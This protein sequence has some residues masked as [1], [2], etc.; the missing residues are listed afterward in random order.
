M[1]DDAEIMTKLERFARKLATDSVLLAVLAGCLVLLTAAATIP[2]RKASVV[3]TNVRAG[4]VE[5][6]MASDYGP[7]VD[8]LLG[9]GASLDAS[10]FDE[11]T[12]LEPG[13]RPSS[14]AH[15]EGEL[16]IALLTLRK[17]AVLRVGSA[18]AQELNLTIV[19]PASSQISAVGRVL[20]NGNPC[21]NSGAA[22]TLVSDRGHEAHLVAR[23]APNQ[24]SDFRLQDLHVSELAFLHH[25]AGAA[26]STGQTSS[27]RSGQLAV[28]ESGESI[29]L[30][31]GADVTLGGVN[32]LV[33]TIAFDKDGFSVAF[34]G[35]AQ[36]IVLREGTDRRDL[37]PSILVWLSR[38]APVT[39]VGGVLGVVLVFLWRARAW[40]DE[41]VD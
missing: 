40:R 33:E 12:S 41:P 29:S 3:L 32:G 30:E 39:I 16:S 7:D 23:M 1:P 25:S 31:A 6:R 17:D 9:K 15:L 24:K 4:D 2:I 28:M 11:V 27:I 34:K 38:L 10:G 21:S 19:G 22:V 13:C 36:E 5:T 8:I 26:G 14:N 35:G 20:K 18:G 37:R